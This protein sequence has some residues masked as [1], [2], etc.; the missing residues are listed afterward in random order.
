MDVWITNA[1]FEIDTVPDRKWWKESERRY[2]KREKKM[3]W[4]RYKSKRR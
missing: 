4:G 3:G 2:E 1:R